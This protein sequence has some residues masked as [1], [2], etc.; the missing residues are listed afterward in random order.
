MKPLLP[1]DSP[2]SASQPIG[3]NPTEPQR[4]RRL[5][6]GSTQV[7]PQSERSRLGASRPAEGPKRPQHVQDQ[8][9]RGLQSSADVR[10][11]PAQRTPEHS[12][13]LDQIVGPM[14]SLKLSPAASSPIRL[15]PPTPPVKGARQ[16]TA[17]APQGSD[18]KAI[19]ELHPISVGT[20]DISLIAG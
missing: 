7:V 6:R 14:Q 8:F 16:A 18:S 12:H 4:G 1:T 9:V 15:P 13:G 19:L 20:R 11:R 5:G 2:Q 10:T 17:A 3:D